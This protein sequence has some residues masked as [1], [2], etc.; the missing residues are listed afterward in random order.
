MNNLVYLDN[1][2]TTRVDDRV[3]ETMLPFFTTHYG[4]AASKHGFGWVAEV[5]VKKAREQVAA[6]IGAEPSEIVFTSGATEAVN[7]ALTGIFK[8]YRSKGDHILTVRTE[9]KA[10]L[11]TCRYLEENEGAKIT[12][13]DVDKEGLIDME[14]LRRAIRPG[15]ILIAVMAAN[16]ET[17][18]IQPLEEIGQLAKERKILF[19]SD[20]TAFAGKMLLDVNEL[21]VDCL[22]LSAHKFHGPKGVGALYIRRRD[23]RVSVLPLIHGGGQEQG[24]RAGTL[25]VPL[26][27]GL[28]KAAEI[29]ASELWDIN[30]HLSRLRAY[31]EHQLLDMAGLRVNGSTRFR[32]Y[33]TS[34]ITFP[35][36]YKGASELLKYYAF[37]SGSACSGI[38]NEPSHVLKAMG[39]GEAEIRNSYRFS[40]SK[41]NTQQETEE[42]VKRI[43]GS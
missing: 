25:N 26:I 37:S 28:G 12:F 18:V 10:V 41:Y 1:N 3:M 19:F 9:H 2:A 15:T 14:E 13:L 4:N 38:N 33:N 36:D 40:F 29:A 43:M 21:H 5:A 17:G 11:D 23:P 34:N 22:S 30:T 31:F 39:L 42:L 7:M 24:R 20:A 16:N 27:A 8:A 32:L 35:S 6:M